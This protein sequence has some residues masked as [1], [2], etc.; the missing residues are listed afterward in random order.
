MLG[1]EL[2]SLAPGTWVL[3]PVT[4][5]IVV[6]FSL[7]SEGQLSSATSA[8]S[9][10]TAKVVPALTRWRDTLERA[11]VA[12]LVVPTLRQDLVTGA[13]TL[14][15]AAPASVGFTDIGTIRGVLRAI[16]AL[17]RVGDVLDAMHS[18]GLV[19]GALGMESIWTLPDGSVGLPDPA[20]RTALP[21]ELSGGDGYAAY[22]APE[23]WHG[24]DP[25]PAADRYAL[26]VIVYELVTG[27]RRAGAVAGGV[28]SAASIDLDLFTP[29]VA[30]TPRQ[31]VVALRRAL[32]TDPL[33][34]FGTAREFVSSCLAAMN[35]VALQEADARRATTTRRFSWTW[36]VLGA[37][38]LALA[39]IGLLSVV[40]QP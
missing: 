32:A 4:R 1:S 7:P 21:V 33:K 3:D 15:Y 22:I 9:A 16:P 23:R 25:S 8:T 34:R 35:P 30:H 29:V 19:H 28:V 18:A 38:G 40:S 26:G 2:R 10:T 5:E 13:A 11:D 17:E 31:L 27:H 39:V 24:G 37:V 20:L 36:V 12:G 6:S 14:R